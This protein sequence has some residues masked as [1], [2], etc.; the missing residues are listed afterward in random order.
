MPQATTDQ[1]HFVEVGHLW[2]V[3]LTQY[4][5]RARGVQAPPPGPARHL[6]VLPRQQVTEP[7][8]VVLADR[9]KHHSACRHVDPH[10][11]RLSGKQDLHS[12]D[13]GLWDGALL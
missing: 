11:K 6:D 13:T 12:K 9:V 10:S 3:P 2:D 8:P 4:D 7:R 1:H 5:H